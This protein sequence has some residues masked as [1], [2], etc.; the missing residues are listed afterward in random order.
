MLT[1]IQYIRPERCHTVAI[2]KRISIQR[3]R[4]RFISVDVRTPGCI[5]P[6]HTDICHHIIH[7]GQHP[8]GVT[9]G[10]NKERIFTDIE[11]TIRIGQQRSR[12]EGRDQ[13]SITRRRN[14]CHLRRSRIPRTRSILLHTAAQTEFTFIAA[15]QLPRFGF[16]GNPHREC[17]PGIGLGCRS[18]ALQLHKQITKG[19]LRC[20]RTHQ[21]IADHICVHIR[22]TA[23]SVLR[24][25]HQA[26]ASIA[27]F[28]QSVAKIDGEPF[29]TGRKHKGLQ[30]RPPAICL[31]HLHQQGGIRFC[32]LQRRQRIKADCTHAIGINRRFQTRCIRIIGLHSGEIQQLNTGFSL[33]V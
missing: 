18:R 11:R 31:L 5:R 17:L 12:T 27:A 21:K 19:R 9:I 8:G 6:E 2:G 1:D 15:R 3:L 28:G 29:E 7:P 25:A 14:I 23:G 16:C 13:C 33:P 24:R 20:G 26:E 10:I 4:Y 30:I 22:C 32:V